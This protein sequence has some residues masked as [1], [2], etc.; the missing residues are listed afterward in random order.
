MSKTKLPHKK[1]DFLLFA[2]MKAEI[3][4]YLVLFLVDIGL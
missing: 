4:K 1:E 2:Y 3:L